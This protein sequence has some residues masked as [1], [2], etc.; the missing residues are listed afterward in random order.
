MSW[1]GGPTGASSGGENVR[2]PLG[3]RRG[4]LLPGGLPRLILVA[5]AVAQ[6]DPA[7]QGGHPTLI[8]IAAFLLRLANHRLDL[9][10]AA[11]AHECCHLSHLFRRLSAALASTVKS[12]SGAPRATSI[13]RT[14]RAAGV[15]TPSS[16]SSARSARSPSEPFAA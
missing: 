2:V 16:T 11:K 5:L 10:A 14:L 7:R 13:S 6:L 4:G 3:A 1:A 8:P 9:V 15:P 12:A